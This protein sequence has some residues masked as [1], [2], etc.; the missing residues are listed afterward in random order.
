MSRA[1]IAAARVLVALGRATPEVAELAK[2][3]LATAVDFSPE[4]EYDESMNQ[5]KALITV[6]D[7]A[8]NQIIARF[9]YS[10]DAKIFAEAAT[11][12]EHDPRELR[13][14]SPTHGLLYRA[15]NGIA[16]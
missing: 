13:I 5:R 2:R 3:D 8:D 7:E 4:K 15:R 6:T 10:D 11:S 1:R 16:L 12:N 9:V 14:D